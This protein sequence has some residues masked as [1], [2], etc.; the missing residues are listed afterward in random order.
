VVPMSP[1]SA[2][3]ERR[4]GSLTAVRIVLSCSVLLRVSGCMRYQR[5][6]WYANL[7][8]QDK[9]KKRATM[10]VARVCVRMCA[11]QEPRPTHTDLPALSAHPP[12]HR[13][14]PRRNERRGTAGT[15]SAARSKSCSASSR[16]CCS[17]RASRRSARTPC[18]SELPCASSRKMQALGPAA[19]RGR[20]LAGA[21]PRSTRSSRAVRW[22]RTTRTRAAWLAG[23][24]PQEPKQRRC[25][26]ERRAPQ[27]RSQTPREWAAKRMFTR[28]FWS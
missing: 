17:R 19:A 15:S 18:A 24:R 5:A 12:T 14:R 27:A 9:H 10:R 7:H 22:L 13:L 4:R 20:G 2:Q 1:Q 3:C 28:R 23:C 8:P 25:Q 6:L 16:S 26:Q 11:M 21:R